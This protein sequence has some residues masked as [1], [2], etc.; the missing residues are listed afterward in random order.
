MMYPPTTVRRTAP[1][2]HSPLAGSAEAPPST[3]IFVGL[4]EAYR[5]SGGVAPGDVL[6]RLFEQHHRGDFVS[7]ARLIVNDQVFA[8][9]WRD[10]FW[11]PM[12]QFHPGDLSIKTAAQR[13]R[14]E[15]P[16]TTSGWRLGTWFTA[17]NDQL[18]GQRPVDLI[19]TQLLAVIDA[20]RNCSTRN[21][22]RPSHGGAARALASA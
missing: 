21:H 18:D 17:Q 12:F 1:S 20:A 5:G 19:D 6:G 10:S 3:S 8:F 13:V 2:G 9:A 11:I 15:L 7:L 16:A 14:A 22:T 4:L